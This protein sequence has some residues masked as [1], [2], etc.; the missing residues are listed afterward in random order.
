MHPQR[1]LIE[2]AMQVVLRED[3]IRRRALRGARSDKHTGRYHFHILNAIEDLGKHIFKTHKY[4]GKALG[5]L[6]DEAGNHQLT[7]QEKE[8]VDTHADKVEHDI[9]HDKFRERFHDTVVDRVQNQFM[10]D[11]DRESQAPT[12]S[13]DARALGRSWPEGT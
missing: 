12:L 7:P 3:D 11:P 6:V 2:S 1:N 9:G 13:A 5:S 10:T 4:S 8:I